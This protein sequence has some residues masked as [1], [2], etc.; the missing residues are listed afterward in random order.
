MGVSHLRSGSRYNSRPAWGVGA[1]GE[2]HYI[3]ITM[4]F[5]LLLQDKNESKIPNRK[6]PQSDKLPLLSVKEL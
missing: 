4:S 6:D 3:K 5:Y 2:T 1:K